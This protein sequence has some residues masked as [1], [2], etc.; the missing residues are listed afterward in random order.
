MALVSSPTKTKKKKDPLS[1]VY[2]LWIEV[3]GT[4]VLNC[5]AQEEFIKP[6]ILFHEIREVSDMCPADVTDRSTHTQYPALSELLS[7]VNV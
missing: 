3:R 5:M 2:W 6:C 7:P 4:T 1:G